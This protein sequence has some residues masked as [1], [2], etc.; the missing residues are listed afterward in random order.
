[1]NSVRLFFGIMLIF[2][3]TG[4]SAV[5]SPVPRPEHPRPDFKRDAWLNLNGEWSFEFDSEDMGLQNNWATEKTN[6]SRNIT[7]PFPWQSK[8]SGIENTEYNG[9]AWYKR[10][11]TVSEKW[12]GQRIFICFGAVDWYSQVWINGKSVGKHE[13]GYSQFEFDITD[14]LKPGQQE[15]VVRAYDDT[16]REQPVGKQVGWYTQTGGIWQTVWLEARP[17]VHIDLIHFTPDPKNQCA[18][19]KLHLISPVADKVEVTIKNDKSEPSST[20]LPAQKFKLNIPAGDSEH[21]LTLK[22]RNPRLWHPD[23]PHL[24][25]VDTGIKTSK[26]VVDLV[27]GYF[28]M[29]TVGI[30]KFAGQDFN[31]I[32]LNG[33]PIYLLGALN[34]AFHPDGIHTYPSEEVLKSDLIRT[35]Q[36]GLNFLRIHIKADEKRFLYWADRLGVLIQADV[37]CCWDWSADA[38]RRWQLTFDDMVQRDFNSPSIFSWCLFNETWGLGG[39]SYVNHPERLAWVKSRMLA[40]RKLDPTRLIE[41]NSP[42]LYD[43]TISDIN[44]WHFYINDYN[45][46]RGHIANVVRETYPGSSFN[47]APGYKQSDAPLINSEFGGISAGGG[48]QDVSWCMKYLTNEL[49]KHPK[50]CGYIYTEL[51]D[52]EWEHNGIMNYDRTPKEFGYGEIS[53]GYDV[54]DVN[55]LD[56]LVLN[57]PPYQKVESSAKVSALFSH[58]SGKNLSAGKL[59]WRMTMFDSLGNEKEADCG[60]GEKLV[61]FKPWTVTPLY[62]I[63]VDMP[64]VQG[65]C[66][67]HVRL[68]SEDGKTELAKN[69]LHLDNSSEL[70]MR[71]LIGSKTLYLRWQPGEFSST[72]W[73]QMLSQ[74]TVQ[75]GKVWGR[76]AGYFEY[77]L[78]LPESVI[79]DD[80]KGAT[81]YMEAAAKASGEKLS[82]PARRRSSD[83]PQTDTVKW[84]STLVVSVNGVEVEKTILPDD[85]A[86]SR[87]VLSHARRL[88]PGSWGY[89]QVISIPP[90]ALARTK[91]AIITLRLESPQGS[92][93]GGLSIFGAEY[94][95]Y[96]MPLTLALE[97]SKPINR[98][99]IEGGS[100]ASFS[101]MSSALISTALSKPETW[102]YCENKPSDNWIKTDFD[103]SG[104]KQGPSGFGTASTP[105]SI[106]GTTWSSKEIWLRKNFDLKELPSAIM[107]QIHYDEDPVIYLNGKKIASFSG[108]RKGYWDLSLSQKELELLRIGKNT[109]SVY[110]RN[111][112]GGQYIDAGLIGIK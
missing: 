88:H 67:L 32:T 109:L 105:G 69:Y 108:Y 66:T 8:L 106:V 27:H 4:A 77:R 53:P 63:N 98:K 71:Q 55:S 21:F 112:G 59:Q 87:G 79:L 26:G 51:Q 42:C 60:R 39:K 90:Q 91:D 94:G 20:P 28:G 89:R 82:W 23:S 49:R 103:D 9:A 80:L 46:A 97:S 72:S 61:A 96:P 6:W 84:P 70:P 47:Y 62:T 73:D 81:L 29:R 7:V 43:H 50:I 86:D 22:V 52:I 48:D 99:A 34:Q 76:G 56:F 3:A 14:Y 45:R 68:Y 110:C 15:V 33:K 18:H 25:F 17:A 40:A 5:V 100:I 74:S 58:F 83:Y 2:L 54:N 92:P 44:S 36:Y 101:R 19:I 75:P 102:R 12:R 95:R 11:F 16:S 107:L 1:M 31:Y 104:W 10:N 41:D 64:K 78:H 30:G 13:G 37:P 111:Q 35:K 24:Y 65:L 85:P 57:A 93:C 38:Q